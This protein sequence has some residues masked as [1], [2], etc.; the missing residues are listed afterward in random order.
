MVQLSTLL[1]SGSKVA[2]DTKKKNRRPSVPVLIKYACWLVWTIVVGYLLYQQENINYVVLAGRVVWFIALL[3][4]LRDGNISLSSVEY[5]IQSKSIVGMIAYA[6]AFWLVTTPQHQQGMKL[7]YGHSAEYCAL[8]ICAGFQSFENP[9]QI[10]YCRPTPLNVTKLTVID[11]YISLPVFLS[12]MIL[13]DVVGIMSVS[14]GRI[15]ASMIIVYK[16]FRSS[17]EYNQISVLKTETVPLKHQF[18]ATLETTV[19]TTPTS[20]INLWRIYGNTYD[21]TAYVEHH[22]GGVE[23]ILLGANRDD[24]TAIFQSYHP[25]NITKAKQVLEKYRVANPKTV[26]GTADSDNDTTTTVTDSDDDT[27][28]TASSTQSDNAIVDDNVTTSTSDATTVV[29]H[30]NDLFYDVLCQR[31]A[32]TLK[33]SNIDP[34]QDRIPNATRYAYYSFLLVAIVSSCVAHCRVSLL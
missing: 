16:F 4:S 27:T 21:M 26:T 11:E 15:L 6:V 22:P 10:M 13:M 24:C 28:S 7:L 5:N 29:A 32:K 34:I 2:A 8:A 14:T 19:K 31:V 20:P 23:A 9:F 3:V 17:M 1:L 12:L 30:E 33:E 25:F 18:T